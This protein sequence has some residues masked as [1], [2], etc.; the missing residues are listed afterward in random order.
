MG[1][2]SGLIEVIGQSVCEIHFECK[3]HKCTV[4]IQSSNLAV[5][6]WARARIPCNLLNGALFMSQTNTGNHKTLEFAQ[7]GYIAIASESVLVDG[8]ATGIIAYT[9]SNSTRSSRRLRIAT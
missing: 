8:K 1:E 2:I 6:R 7:R 3:N 5:A 9:N 4:I